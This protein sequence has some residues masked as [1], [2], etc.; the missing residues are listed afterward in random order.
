MACPDC[1]RSETPASFSEYTLDELFML[2]REHTRPAKMTP[3]AYKAALTTL[4]TI[5]FIALPTPT[6]GATA[7]QAH[8][9]RKLNA[10]D[11]A[12]LRYIRSEGSIVFEEGSAKGALPGHM[13]ARLDIGATFTASFTLYANGGTL[14]GHGSATPHGSGRYESFS[15]SLVVDRGTGRYAHAHGHAGLYGVFDRSTYNVEVQTTGTL[16]Y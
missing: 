7:P 6:S 2:S 9:A 3:S 16:S 11:T 14:K 13:R 15:G 10:T 8:A 5:A 1:K 4:G 12:H